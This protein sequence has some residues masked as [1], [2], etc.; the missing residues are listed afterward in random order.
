[1][2]DH[3]SLPLLRATRFSKALVSFQNSSIPCSNCGSSRLLDT[4]LNVG[5]TILNVLLA[6]P[7]TASILRLG[8]L[9][10]GVGCKEDFVIPHVLPR[11]GV[12]LSYEIY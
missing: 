9:V 4:S 7:N 12:V 2:N 11:N 3:G 6:E 10:E 5:H 8:A 1:M